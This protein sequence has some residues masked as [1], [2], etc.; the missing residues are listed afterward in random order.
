MTSADCFQLLSLF[1]RV[2]PA[3]FFRDL[4]QKHGYRFRDGIYPPSVVVWLMIWQ[5]LQGNRSA[6]A[7]VQH[8]L[9]GGAHERIH[10]CQR[11]R[12]AQVSAATGGYC[13]A[14]QKLP[15]LIASEVMERMVEQLRAEMQEG[16][17]G[18]HRPVFL[19]DGSTLQLRHEEELVR[20]FSPGRNQ[21]GEN[22]WP[23]LQIVVFHDVFSGLALRPSWGPMYGDK[24]VS[25]QGLAREA[26]E[27]LPADAVVL[28]DSNFGIFAFA[29]G[30]QQSQR[31]MVLR[32]TKARAKKI[33]GVE[34]AAGMDRKVTWSASSWEA[35]TYP[36]LPAGATV[37]GRVVVCADPSRPDELLYLFTTLD[38]EREQ[39][40]GMYRLR[41]N[42]ETDLRSIK[43]TVE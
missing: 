23:V 3:S 42:V 16:W 39:I 8:L 11:W 5:K 25:E 35:H 28:A 33:L 22:H 19:I 4:A 13:Q 21:H 40:L 14:R 2:V 36:E 31:A 10:G 7:A 38:L 15:K 41:W 17:E 34:P 37:E 6:A 12:R 29:Y 32:L 9:Q 24:P 1:C 26:L 30:V 43:R 20:E 18:L 27:R